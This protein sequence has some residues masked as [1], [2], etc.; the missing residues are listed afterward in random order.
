MSNQEEPPETPDAFLKNVGTR[1]AK[2]DAV[3]SDLAAILAEHILASDV[4]DDAVAQAKA[5]VVALAK[6]RAQAPVEVANG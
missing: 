6:T 3:D 1:L 5:A 4:A 2:R